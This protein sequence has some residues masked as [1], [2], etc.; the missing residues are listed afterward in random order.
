MSEPPWL[1]CPPRL[2]LV[3]VEEANAAPV[4]QR[5]DAHSQRRG[6]KISGRGGEGRGGEGQEKEEHRE[7]FVPSGTSRPNT[8]CCMIR[9][10]G[11]CHT[12]P[13][14]HAVGQN[15]SCAAHLVPYSMIPGVSQPPSVTCRLHKPPVLAY[16]L[17]CW[18]LIK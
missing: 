5:R 6:W 9:V 7:G 8:R 12:G 16:V 10:P 2:L 15:G 17:V 13:G 4:R 1:L 18:G 14:T 11:R 3:V